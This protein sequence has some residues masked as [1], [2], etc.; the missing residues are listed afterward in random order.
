[1]GKKRRKATRKVIAEETMC[2]KIIGSL[3]SEAATKTDTMLPNQNSESD[4]MPDA[5]RKRRLVKE[6][7]AKI[8]KATIGTHSERRWYLKAACQSTRMKRIAALM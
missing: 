4:S 1:M 6:F 7:A 3:S 5:A 8:A 2:M